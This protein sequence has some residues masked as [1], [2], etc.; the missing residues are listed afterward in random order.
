MKEENWNPHIPL[1]ILQW[2]AHIYSLRIYVYNAPIVINGF[3]WYVTECDRKLPAIRVKHFINSKFRQTLSFIEFGLPDCKQSYQQNQINVQ[4]GLQIFIFQFD[5]PSC[6]RPL[7]QVPTFTCVIQLVFIAYFLIYL[8]ILKDWS[9]M[10]CNR[11]EVLTRTWIVHL[12]TR[13]MLKIL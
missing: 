5:D 2:K 3:L 12:Y 13:K 11:I 8:Y 7:N 4:R 6:H 1:Q 9:A 10:T